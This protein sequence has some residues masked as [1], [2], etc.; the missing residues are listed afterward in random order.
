M[1]TTT[2]AS[3]ETAFIL[4]TFACRSFGANSRGNLF[5]IVSDIVLKISTIA[6]PE[7]AFF[8]NT[9]A[10]R[11]FGANSRGNPYAAISDIVLKIVQSPL[12]KLRFSLI[13]SRVK[14]FDTCHK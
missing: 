12:R 5:A 7:I 13:I 1:P 9:F 4:N 10:C 14:P 3:P 2:F 8:L 11:S 6:S